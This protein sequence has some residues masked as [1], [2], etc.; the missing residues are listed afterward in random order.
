[1]KSSGAIILFNI[2]NQDDYYITIG[3][4]VMKAIMM[5]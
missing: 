3:M 2:L 1:M 5:Y 4:E